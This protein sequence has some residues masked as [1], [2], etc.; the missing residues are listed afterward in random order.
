M[1][2]A[3]DASSVLWKREPGS[4]EI[5]VAS[6][7]EVAGELSHQFPC[8][9]A[10]R[11]YFTLV[12]GI[13]DTDSRVLKY[14][15]AGHP[16]MIQLRRGSDP[17]L[18]RS[19]GLPIALVPDDLTKSVIQQAEVSLDPG[20]RLYLYSDGIPEARSSDGEQYG[21]ARTAD[22]LQSCMDRSLAESID[23]LLT[24]VW[25]WAEG[26]GPDDDVSI[27]AIEIEDWP[28]TML[29]GSV[30]IVGDVVDPALDPEASEAESGESS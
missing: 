6:P 12:Y 28:Q 7:L 11:Q 24:E 8:N 14:V 30:E 5:R 29:A 10:T 9:D 4:G 13:L 22:A 1:S 19:T 16:P 27:L 20:D 18:H 25:D 17:N 23:F 15:S 21:E 26:K 2:G 3:P